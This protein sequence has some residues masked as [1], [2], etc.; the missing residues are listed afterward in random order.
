MSGIQHVFSGLHNLLHSKSIQHS[1]LRRRLAATV[2]ITI[3]VDIIGT[4]GMYL[5]ERHHPASDIH[6]LWEAFYFTTSQMTTLS[7]SMA[8]PVT[9]IGQSIVLF[10]DVYAITVVSTL[11]GMF[12]AFFY[13]QSDDK[14]RQQQRTSEAAPRDNTSA[15][16]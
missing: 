8:N 10:L 6:T 14:R 16:N 12:G 7:S 15:Q 3:V 11:A 5:V 4:L 9:I 1:D 13:H 2:V